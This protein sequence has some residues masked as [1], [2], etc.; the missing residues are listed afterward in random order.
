MLIFLL[1]ILNNGKKN[2]NMFLMKT[3]IVI[4]FLFL[5]EAVAS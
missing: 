2:V 4:D 3:L 1:S 5:S